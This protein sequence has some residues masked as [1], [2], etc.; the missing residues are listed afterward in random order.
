MYERPDQK[1]WGLGGG[2]TEDGRFIV[3]SLSEGTDPKNRLYVRDLTASPLESIENTRRIPG[4]VVGD[5]VAFYRF[6]PF[7][8]QVNVK[9]VGDTTYFTSGVNGGASVG[10]P[11]AVLATVGVRYY[12]GAR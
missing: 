4:Y 3:M 5:L 12:V 7:E 11:L 8:V 6:A 1:E 10:D 9:N 2:V